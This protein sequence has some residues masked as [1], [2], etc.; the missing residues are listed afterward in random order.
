MVTRGAVALLMLCLLAVPAAAQDTAVKVKVERSVVAQN[1]T[2]EVKFTT[3]AGDASDPDWSPLSK[4]FHLRSQNKSFQQTVVNGVARTMHGWDVSLQ[5]KRAGELQIPPLQFGAVRSPA[6]PITVQPQQQQAQPGRAVEEFFI[7]VSAQPEDP[8]VQAQV[9]FTLRVF[10]LRSLRGSVTP[11]R[12]G[13]GMIVENLEDARN[14]RTQRDGRQYEVYERRL[15]IY[16]QASGDVKIEP[17][18]VVGSYVNQGRRFSLNKQSRALT[19][20][21]R[22]VPASF[23][24]KFWLP[25]ERFEIRED[26]SADLSLWRAGE[27]VTRTLHLEA[28]GLLARQVP[29]V[30]LSVGDGFRFYAESAE[31][32]KEPRGNTIVGKR[33][34]SAVLIPAQAG[35]YTLPPIKVPWW[36]TRTDRLEFAELPAKDVTISEAAFSELTMDELPPAGVGVND[37]GQKTAA[38]E[39]ADK[40][41][42]PWVWISVVLLLGWLA[43]VIAMWRGVGLY[44]LLQGARRRRETMRERRGA[45]RQACLDNDAAAARD[46]LMQWA[47]MMWPDHAPTSIGQ[48]GT[49]CGEVVAQQLRGLERALYARDDTWRGNLLWD[50]FTSQKIAADSNP[51]AR[52]DKLEPLHRL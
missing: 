27:P 8:Y 33:Q 41:G 4:D 19:L 50:A 9:L 5:P 11:P 29:E 48:V 39:A 23:P 30:D 25:A 46:A 28:S 51:Q 7:E 44:R 15:L 3:E 47:R 43:T 34:Q 37:A 38:L 10:M 2:F 16:P 31:F 13:S 26:W 1:E 18:S 35:T 32:K 20:K 42:N 36:N 22:Q 12:S 6:T 49:R 24:G 45:I 17:V 52:P 21:V 40:A 14:Y